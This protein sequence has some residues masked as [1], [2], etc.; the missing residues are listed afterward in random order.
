MAA[1]LDDALDEIAAIQRGHATNDGADH[2]RPRWPMIVLRTPKGWTG[3]KVVDGLPAEGTLRS[4]QVP[5]ADVRRRTPSTSRSSR[6]GCAATGREELFDEH[7][8][9][10]RR[11]ARRSRRAA[12]GGWAPT[13]TPT[14]GC[15][16]ATSSCPTSATT[17]SPCRRRRRRPARRRA[18]SA[19][20]CATSIRANTTSELPPLRPRRDRVEP[21]RRGLRGDRPRLGRRDRAPATITSP[22]TGA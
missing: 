13:R 15:C 7:G 1:A 20:G 8:A 18:C 9:L 14:A 10:R 2:E 17:R 11:A 19:R 5:L 3:P 16:C 6:R 12:S 4:H 22:R 21:P